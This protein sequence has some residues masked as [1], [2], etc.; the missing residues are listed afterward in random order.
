MNVL[1]TLLGSYTPHQQLWILVLVLGTAAI[2]VS[3]IDLFMVGRTPALDLPDPDAYDEVDHTVCE[4]PGCD[5]ILCSCDP[6]ALCPDTQEPSTCS[7][8]Q[9]LCDDH[10]FTDCGACCWER[11]DDRRAEVWLDERAERGW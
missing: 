10:Q 6:D 8:H 7:H 2:I 1:D 3:S 11:E 9:L 5:V 4:A